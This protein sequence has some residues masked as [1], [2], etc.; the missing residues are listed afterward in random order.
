LP[1]FFQA[2]PPRD[3]EHITQKP[4]NVMR[5][6]VR[7]APKGGAVLDPFMGSGST[8]VAAATEGYGFIG[9]EMSPAHCET[10]RSRIRGAQVG[11]RDDGRQLA[12]TEPGASS[13][14]HAAGSV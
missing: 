3:R 6:L 1:G 11:Y 14:L 9:V 10:A 8:G 5:Q 7:I 13:E 12:L 2:H 4:L